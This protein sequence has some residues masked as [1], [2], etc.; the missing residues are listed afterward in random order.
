[1]IKAK[2]GD[3]VRLRRRPLVSLFGDG[4]RHK[5]PGGEGVISRVEQDDVGFIYWVRLRKSGKEHPCRRDSLVVH[6][7]QSSNR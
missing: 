4:T 2:P 6:R 1:M 3:P 7:R 5:G